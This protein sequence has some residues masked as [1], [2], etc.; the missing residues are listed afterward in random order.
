MVKFPTIRSIVKSIKEKKIEPLG[1]LSDLRENIEHI[2]SNKDFFTYLP[3]KDNLLPKKIH[4]DSKLMGMP[5]A[6]KDIIDVKGW[7]T[8]FG[9]N[10]FMGYTAPSSADIVKLYLR[11][12]G[13]ILG[14]TQTH[15]FA[16]GIITP[17]SSNPWNMGRIT[18]GSSG[19]SAAAISSGLSF[20]SIGTDT[21]GSVRIPAAFCGVVGYKPPSGKLSTKGIFP[22]SYS[23][24]TV[25]FFSRRVDDLIFLLSNIGYK[26]NTKPDYYKCKIGIINDLLDKSESFVSNKVK[27]VVSKLS[28]EIDASFS[29]IEIDYLGGISRMDDII[30]MAENASIHFGLMKKFK[31]R[32]SPAT[33]RQIE[34]GSKITVEEYISAMKYRNIAIKKF[35]NIS[36]NCDL[37]ISPTQPIVAPR[38]DD[39]RLYDEKFLSKLMSFTNLYNF[40]D[41][42][43]ISLPIGKV[44]GLPV[45]IQIAAPKR[46]EHILFYLAQEMEKYGLVYT[47]IPEKFQ[48]QLK[49]ERTNILISDNEE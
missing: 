8:K 18:G 36:N 43:A 33:S 15:E 1:L 28:S 25:G 45:S 42:C 3:N 37:L 29:D 22:E 9:S 31:D 17:Q 23:L 10:V 24:D 13:S 35:N 40:V 26:I 48:K 46:K 30:D 7:P 49:F 44:F 21:A 27:K 4:L 20:L 34:S 2:D 41:F 47:D 12:G 5:I 14:K 6:I 11:S 16:T 38:K 19:G 32:Y 39:A